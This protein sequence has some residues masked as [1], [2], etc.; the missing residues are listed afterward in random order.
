MDETL[1]CSMVHFDAAG[2]AAAPHGRSG[3]LLQQA[4]VTFVMPAAKIIRTD[5]QFNWPKIKPKA[6]EIHV[7]LRSIG[8]FGFNVHLLFPYQKLDIAPHA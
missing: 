4:K 3:L 1:N 6:A 2:P 8:T 5:S 7:S